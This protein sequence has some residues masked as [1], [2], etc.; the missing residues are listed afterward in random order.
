VM[1]H[2]YAREILKRP[3]RRRAELLDRVP[4]IFQGQVQTHLEIADMREKHESNNN[5]RREGANRN[6]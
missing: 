3:R 4:E 6:D 1:P 2:Q 5:A